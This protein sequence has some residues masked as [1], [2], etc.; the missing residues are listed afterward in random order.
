MTQRHWQIFFSIVYVLGIL[1]A[2]AAQPAPTA[3]PPPTSPVAN[4]I[5][6]PLPNSL[7]EITSTR[8]YRFRVDPAQTTVEYAVSEVLLGNNQITRGRT[9]AVEGEFQLY[10]QNGQVFVALSNFQVDL[11]TLTTDNNVRDQA[12]R[13]NW[14]E[15][16]K[17]PKAIFVANAVQ[18]LPADAVQNQPYKFQVTGDMT[19]RNIT[20]PLTFEV[21][22]TVTGQTIRGEGT[23]T[24]Y[25]KDFGFDPP[26]IAGT[27]IVS[28]PVK[29]TIKGVANLI[30]G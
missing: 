15:S 19:I 6:N 18:G 3:T 23:A 11:R 12:I 14:L 4:G 29:V 1:P 27:T 16:D 7:R 26:S 30:E 8:V 25:M 9:N 22:V 24:L 13:K 20:R 2:C 10:M 28:D 5:K 17:F 21:T